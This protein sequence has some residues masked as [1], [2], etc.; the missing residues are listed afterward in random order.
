M[1]GDVKRNNSPTAGQVD[2]D[3]VTASP[4]TVM[5]TDRG[6]SAQ[7]A[8][9]AVSLL[10]GALLTGRVLAGYM[11]DRFFAPHVAL[12]FFIAVAGGLSLLWGGAT[13]APAFLAAFLVGRISSACH[14]GLIHMVP[15]LTD[16]GM[17]A[18]S[19]ALAVSLFGGALLLGRV[20][21]G[22]M[23]DRFFC[24]A[25]R[26]G[27]LYGCRRRDFAVVGWGD[28]CARNYVRHPKVA[29]NRVRSRRTVP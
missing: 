6:M 17:S 8:S 16:R 9:L 20:M 11:L 23:L 4:S 3:V 22:Y 13:G 10:G 25:C 19:A 14:A 27:I 21:A 1:K 5:L 12:G 26:A 24:S 2:T 15:M 28:R 7:S 18:P 29:R